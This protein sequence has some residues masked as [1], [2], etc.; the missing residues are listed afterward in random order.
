[1]SLL[2]SFGGRFSNCPRTLCALGTALVVFAFAAPVLAEDDQPFQ[3]ESSSWISFDRYNEK[4]GHWLTPDERT[5]AET[6]PVIVPPPVTPADMPVITPPTRPVETAALPGVNND[7][8]VKVSSTEDDN[9]KPPSLLLHADDAKP[10]KQDAEAQASWQ[11]AAAFART[12]RDKKQV[13][14]TINGHPAYDVRLSYFP[15]FITPMP[16]PDVK[17]IQLAEPKMSLPETPP[18]APASAPTSKPAATPAPT[19]TVAAT[20]PAVKPATKQA[21]AQPAAPKMSAA[22]AAACAALDAYKKRQ[23]AAIE[24]DRKTLSALQDAIAKLGLN[25]QL[26][27]MTGANGS[28]QASMPE[29]PPASAK[30]P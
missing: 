5:A 23:L 21:T 16:K 17:K 20:P 13:L 12:N 8:D 2:R 11:D 27:F 14:E 7:F 4:P 26:D 25:K 6:Q 19:A 10:T 29:Q 28:V 30:T 15:G 3:M 24:S 18:Q 1:M 22:D 9:W